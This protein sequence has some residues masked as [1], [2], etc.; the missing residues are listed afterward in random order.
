M[1]SLG[2]LLGSQITGTVV[3]PPQVEV[4][5]ACLMILSEVCGGDFKIIQDLP[6]VSI[7]KVGLKD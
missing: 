7:D 5:R 1:I 2:D 6:G 4:A 3:F